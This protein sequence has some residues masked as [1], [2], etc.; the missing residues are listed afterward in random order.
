MTSTSQGLPVH[1]RAPGKVNLYLGVGAVGDDG[2][3]EVASVYQAVSLY[4]DVRVWRSSEFS[5]SF[6]GPIDCSALP[7]DDRNLAVRAARLVATAGGVDDG[8]RIEIEKSVPI[9]GGM[10]GGSADAAATLV[11]C[12][13]L[14]NTGLTREQLHGLAAELG[15]DVPFALAGGTAIG[16]GRGDELS[17]VLTQGR[18]DWVLVLPR[19]E[20]STPAVYRE[21]DTHRER[22]AGDLGPVVEHP[23]VSTELLQALR[24]G[25]PELLAESLANDLQA[26]AIHLSDEL[27]DVL[28][29]GE[30]AGALAG[31]VSGSGPTVAF[32]AEDRE[33][34]IDLQIALS[35]AQLR[36]VR[37]SAP[38]HGARVLQLDG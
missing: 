30:R 4:E 21:L 13:A 35:A 37:V 10:G 26:P 23:S 20:L 31:L 24:A 14:W 19:G 6:S 34:A 29:L 27:S 1:A 9:A 25:D 15:A 22:H 5:L 18:F 2:Y 11:A 17:P 33:S 16:L 28:E 7:T 38:V 12:D 3:H 32:L 36:A 8:V